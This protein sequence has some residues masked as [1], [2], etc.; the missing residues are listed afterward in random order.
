MIP[1]TNNCDINTALFSVTRRHAEIYL[2]LIVDKVLQGDAENSVDPYAKIKGLVKQKDQVKCQARIKGEVDDYCQR[3]GRFRQP[4][5]WSA[6]QVFDPKGN[7]NVTGDSL[8]ES[9]FHYVGEK[10]DTFSLL[11]TLAEVNKVRYI[12]LQLLSFV[13]CADN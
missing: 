7:L 2:F 12:R 3:M 1:T 8:F 9:I 11:N 5:G 10:M 13:C 4:F 6:I